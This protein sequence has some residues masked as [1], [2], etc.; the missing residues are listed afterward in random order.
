MKYNFLKCQMRT[1]FFISWGKGPSKDASQ[2]FLFVIFLKTADINEPDDFRTVAETQFH[3]FSCVRSFMFLR[4]SLSK[5]KIITIGT[6]TWKSKRPHDWVCS[7]LCINVLHILPIFFHTKTET[8]TESRILVYLPPQ[9]V[10]AILT[11]LSQY[12]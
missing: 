8:T 4:V 3:L 7:P 2:Y 9:H 1:F 6:K 10:H 5:L 12:R 11:Q